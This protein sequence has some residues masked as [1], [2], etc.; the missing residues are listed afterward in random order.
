MIEQQDISA[1][2][3]A[4]MRA[5]YG[6][7]LLPNQVLCALIGSSYLSLTAFLQGQWGYLFRE[8]RLFSPRAPLSFSQ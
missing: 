2:A 7:N 4:S 6:E 3:R 8:E 1:E 5:L